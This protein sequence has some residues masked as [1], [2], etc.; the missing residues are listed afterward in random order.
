ME[1]TSSIY[2]ICTQ[3]R[4]IK[5][6]F[7]TTKKKL[8]RDTIFL[9]ISV[10]LSFR[11]H[12]CSDL[13]NHLGCIFFPLTLLLAG[14]LLPLPPSFNFISLVQS[15]FSIF[16][17]FFNSLSPSSPPRL[18]SRDFLFHLHVWSL[19]G[20]RQLSTGRDAEHTGWIVMLLYSSLI[21]S[22]PWH[23]PWKPLCLI[24]CLVYSVLAFRKKNLPHRYFC[25]G[26]SGILGY[27]RAE[28]VKIKQKDCNF[29]C[30]RFYCS[31]ECISFCWSLQCCNFSKQN[32]LA[33]CRTGPVTVL[34]TMMVGW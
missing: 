19:S 26:Y 14:L 17:I 29:S 8:H 15:P 16:S 31:I 2:G 4:F 1:A 9:H 24:Y 20:P 25:R 11:L 12:L 3:Q 5:S 6:H 23:H 34:W 22:D 7:P 30:A 21:T 27:R 32:I 13:F 28:Q 10:V 33:S 18:L